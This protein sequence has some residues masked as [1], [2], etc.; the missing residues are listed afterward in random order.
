MSTYGVSSTSPLSDLDDDPEVLFQNFLIAQWNNTT[1]GINKT[2]IN[3]GYEPDQNTTK[4]LVIKVEESFTDLNTI[5]LGDRYTQYDAVLD[6]KIWER[7]SKW[8][9]TT[10]NTRRFALR[11]YITRFIKTHSRTGDSGKLK[12]F[13]LLGSR[14]IGE[15]ER[16]DWHLTIVTFRAQTWVV[17][18]SQ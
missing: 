6:V 15:S 3:F 13:Y 14:N 4:S 2:D 1:A 18:A 7:N 17:D 9:K 5:D 16:T 11:K 8:Y 12:H 10:P